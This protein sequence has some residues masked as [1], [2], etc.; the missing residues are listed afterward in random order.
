MRTKD[1]WPTLSLFVMFT[2]RCWGQDT[3][4]KTLQGWINLVNSDAKLTSIIDKIGKADEVDSA[5]AVSV[6]ARMYVWY[7]RFDDPIMKAE[8]LELIA[9]H[10]NGAEGQMIVIA[11]MDPNA[12]IDRRGIFFPWASRLLDNVP[13][14][15]YMYDVMVKALE[16]N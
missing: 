9:I 14:S 4:A 1:L 3:N 7:N 13:P 2:L 12:S 5:D 15:Q 8:R 6:N 10:Q 16:E 11:I